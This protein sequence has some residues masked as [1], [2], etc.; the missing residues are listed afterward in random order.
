MPSEA[1]T[2][3]EVAA[4]RARGPEAGTTYEPISTHHGAAGDNQIRSR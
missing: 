4:A 3:V 1:N 2:P